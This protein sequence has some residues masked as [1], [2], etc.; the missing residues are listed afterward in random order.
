MGMMQ[1]DIPRHLLV[2]DWHDVKRHSL[3]TCGSLARIAGRVMSSVRYQK[4]CRNGLLGAIFGYMAGGL[5]GAIVGAII[6]LLVYANRRT[7]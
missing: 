7:A 2:A 3:E 6:V 5:I 4:H 1:D